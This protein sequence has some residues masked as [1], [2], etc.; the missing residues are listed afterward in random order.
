MAYTVTV[1][2]SGTVGAVLHFYEVDSSGNLVQNLTATESAAATTIAISPTSPGA[3]HL[4]VLVVAD[5]DGT[6]PSAT[7]SSVSDGVNTW[8]KAVADNPT[9]TA[10]ASEQWYTLQG[11]LTGGPDKS[12]GSDGSGTAADSGTTAT[13]TAAVEMVI[14]SIAPQGSTN[15]MSGLTSGFTNDAIATTSI[16][17]FGVQEQGGHQKTAVTGTFHYGGTISTSRDWAATVVTYKLPAPVATGGLQD[18]ALPRIGLRHPQVGPMRLPGAPGFVQKSIWGPSSGVPL[19]LTASGHDD[20]QGAAVLDQSLLAAGRDDSQGAA[21]LDQS[22]LAAGRDDSQ[23][24][25]TLDQSLLAAG[26]DDSQGTAVLDQSLLAAGHDDSQ[27]AAL[28]DQSLLAAGHDDSQ[29][30]SSLTLAIALVVAGHDDSMG[31]AVLALAIPLTGSG[32]D[33][34]RGAAILELLTV[35]PHLL[36]GTVRHTPGFRTHLQ[37]TPPVEVR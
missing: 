4:L 21:T 37:N 32:H 27:G 13:T 22:L 6:A 25:A 19:D 2:F 24:A 3:G 28:L 31:S 11:G 15:T 12:S 29:G 20:S 36:Q 33:D 5:Y 18:R 35:A 26:R 8:T 10:V 16:A 7:V 34:S 1:T 17:G 30:V 14:G 9:A 23:G